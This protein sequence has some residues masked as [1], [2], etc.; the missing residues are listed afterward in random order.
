M[1]GVLREV[2]YR[3]RAG[4]EAVP[5][6]WFKVGKERDGIGADSRAGRRSRRTGRRAGGGRAFVVPQAFAQDRFQVG[7]LTVVDDQL[8]LKAKAS[9]S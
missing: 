2:F 9:R 1:S 7:H 6:R 4:S 5:A 8:A 3:L